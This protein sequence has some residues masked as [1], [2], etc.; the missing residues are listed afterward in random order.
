MGLASLLSLAGLLPGVI[1]SGALTSKVGKKNLY[2]LGMVCFGVFPLL[3]LVDVTSVPILLAATVLAN[4]GNGIM[5]PQMYSILADNTDY[6]EIKTGYRAEAAVASLSSFV[7]KFSMG[8]GGAIPGYLLAAVGFD[9][10]AAVQPE[11]VNAMIINCAIVIPAV[12]CVVSAIVMQVFYPLN[13]KKLEEQ[14]EEIKKL[15]GQA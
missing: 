9:G 4:L 6:V 7:A 15:H 8:I 11:G 12:L 13:K 3:K 5:M 10:K 1:V 14:T 2:I